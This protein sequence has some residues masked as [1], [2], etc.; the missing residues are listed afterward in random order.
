M[1]AGKELL[2]L[3]LCTADDQKFRIEESKVYGDVKN[4]SLTL[5]SVKLQKLQVH[6]RKLGS[7]VLPS[8]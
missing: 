4:V 3:F 6:A 5:R 8:L 1:F 2:E 7:V